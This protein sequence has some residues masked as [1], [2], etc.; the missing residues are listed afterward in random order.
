VNVLGVFLDLLVSWRWTHGL[1][2]N[3]TGV[4]YRRIVLNSTRIRGETF[5]DQLGHS[6]GS[7]VVATVAA[8]FCI[9]LNVFG[10]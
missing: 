2:V 3:S 8:H 6:Q 10:I 4:C 9:R 5:M 7:L 1:D